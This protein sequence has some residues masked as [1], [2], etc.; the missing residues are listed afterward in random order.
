MDHGGLEVLAHERGPG[1]GEGGGDDFGSA[2]VDVRDE[3]LREE[4][5]VR[6][7]ARLGA[8]EPVDLV[9]VGEQVQGGGQSPFDRG[10]DEPRR[11]LDETIRTGLKIELDKQHTRAQPELTMAKKRVSELEQERKRLA[12]GVVTGTIPSDLAREEHVRIDEELDQAQ[13]ILSTSSPAGKPDGGVVPLNRRLHRFDGEVLLAAGVAALVAAKAGEVGV[14]ALS[15]GGAQPG[16]ALAAEDAALEVVVVQAGLLSGD[17]VSF[18]DGLDAVEQRLRDERLVTSLVLDVL[19]RHV[20]EVVAV[21]QQVVHVDGWIGPDGFLPCC[22]VATFA[23]GILNV[24]SR[25]A[26]REVGG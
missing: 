22:R 23:R 17:V 25:G 20:T 8:A 21:A 11:G 12:R 7:A 13:R 16:A 15:E 24:E 5:L 2:G 1:L 10:V 9:D 6:E 3:Q 19:E 14:L 26:L 4:A 18:E